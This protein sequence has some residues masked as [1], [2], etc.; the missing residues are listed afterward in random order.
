MLRNL[1]RPALRATQRRC[2]S[3]TV[4]PSEIP[5]ANLELRWKTLTSQEQGSLAKQ[6]EQAQAGDWTKLSLEQKKAAYWVAFGPHGARAPLTGPNHSLK[7]FVGTSAVVG[8]AGALF[9]WIR[10]KG[11]EAPKT[12]T[13]EWQE[14]TN[15]YARENKINPITGISSEGYKGDGFVHIPKN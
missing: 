11:G 5:L 10:A 2:A 12:T 1:A 13:K 4:T 9:L 15:E 7:V 14:A 6:L 3:T 8:A